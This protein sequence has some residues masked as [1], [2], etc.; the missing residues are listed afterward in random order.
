MWT[1][2]IKYPD[3]LWSDVGSESSFLSTTGRLT[4]VEERLWGFIQLLCFVL[5]I[6]VTT[7]D[8]APVS[9]SKIAIKKTV[10]SKRK[11]KPAASQSVGSG[12]REFSWAWKF[13]PD[14]IWP[15]QISPKLSTI[16]GWIALIFCT[17]GHESYWLLWTPDSSSSSP[18]KSEFSLIQW[19]I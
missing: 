10:W 1:L 14:L 3:I 15:D 18:S 4:A 7:D 12:I 16:F 11:E 2:G 17:D 6:P 8:F 19:N 13:V 9:I 5:L